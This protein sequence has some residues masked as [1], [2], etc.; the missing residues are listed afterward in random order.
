MQSESSRFV[1][2]N[3]LRL[4]PKSKVEVKKDEHFIKI[5]LR[6]SGAIGAFQTHSFH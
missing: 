1:I 5:F 6:L 2:F 3:C 4:A